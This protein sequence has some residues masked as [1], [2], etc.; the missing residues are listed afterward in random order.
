MHIILRSLLCLLAAI[1]V[2]LAS[3]AQAPPATPSGQFLHLSD[4]HFDPFAE[5]ALVSQLSAAPVDQWE[6]ILQGSAQ[7]PETDN[8]QDSNYALIVS[9]LKEAKTAGNYDYIVYTGDYLSHRFMRNVSDYISD[10]AAQKGLCREIG[11]VCELDD[12]KAFSRNAVDR[13]FGQ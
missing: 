10:P 4:I 5:P 9:A 12:R 7:N 2:P 6:A 8:K 11:G 1:L 3:A 13:D